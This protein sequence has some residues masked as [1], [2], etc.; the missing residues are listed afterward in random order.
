[1]ARREGPSEFV[2]IGLG[3]FGYSLALKLTQ[4]GHSV[5][6]IDSNPRLV[7]EVSGDLPGA[8]ALD[9]TDEEA[10]REIGVEYFP[11]AVVAIGDDFESNILVTALL[12]ELGIGQVICKASTVRQ[13][14]ILLRV[15]A[16]AVM[17][18]EHEAGVRLA[19]ELASPGKVL[20]RLEL[21]PGISVSEV[22]CPDQLAG[23]TLVDLDLP[24]HLGV[25]VVAL[26]GAREVAMP[27]PN[28]KLQ[29]GDRLVLVG[30]D[31]DIARL[32]TWHPTG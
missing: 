12:K 32:E 1:M 31:Q 16:D 22:P 26:R 14:K 27:G 11:T 19:T 8:V 23:R 24:K 7:Q 4:L 25:T 5:L 18:P 20:E 13:Q 3:R 21:Q 15:G 9:A 2:V 10:L 30:T 28:E 17:L 29:A 6:A